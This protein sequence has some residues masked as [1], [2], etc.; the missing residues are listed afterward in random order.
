MIAPGVRARALAIA[1]MCGALAPVEAYAARGRTLHL[2]VGAASFYDDNILQYS[3][4]QLRDFEL[5]LHPERYAV[6]TTDDIV[7]NPSLS[8]GW[9]LDAGRGRRH[10]I[11]L[12]SEGDFHGKNGTADFH[13]FSLAATE[14][15]SRDRDL[16]AGYYLLPSFYLRQLFDDDFVPPYAGLSKYRRA[17]FRLQ[18]ARLGWAQRLTRRTLVDFDY[19]FEDRDYNH[20]FDERDS[21]LHQGQVGVSLVRLPRRG[22]ASLD[23][24]YRVSHARAEDGNPNDTAPDP[25]VSYHGLSVGVGGRVEIARSG[26]WRWLADLRYVLE[27]RQFDS[28]RPTDRYHFGRDDLLHSIEL[29]LRTAYRPHWSMR[30][31]DRLEHNTATLGGTAPLSADA[32]SYQANQ[33]GVAIEWTGDVWS[34][35]LAPPED[36]ES[37]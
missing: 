20:D 25:D 4:G 2:T 1:L 29:G 23:L 24:G 22:V 35:A 19:Q 13:S 17:D 31:F 5:G 21:Q 15:W 33:V 8:L 10:E 7:L 14:S 34:G 32:G 36:A 18:I 3:D 26:A 16:T 30:L 11:R 6:E 28:D 12:K 37:P 9:E 27:T